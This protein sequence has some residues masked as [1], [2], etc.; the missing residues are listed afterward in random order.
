MINHYKNK[1]IAVAMSGGVDSSVSAALLKKQE[2]NVFGF[3]MVQFS[4]NIDKIDNI[5][6]EFINPNQ[7]INEMKSVIDAKKV[8]NYIGIPHF[9]IDLRKDFYQTVVQYFIEEYKNGKTPNPC[10][11]C[12]PTIKWGLF[13]DNIERILFNN[14]N[15]NDFLFATG[16]YAKIQQLENGLSAIFKAEDQKKDQTYMLWGL[17]QSQIT[18]TI[19]PL[20]GFR[21]DQSVA[22]EGISSVRSLA[23]E[24][25]LEIA[26]KKDSQDICFIKGKYSDF[27]AYFLDFVSGDIVYQ[28]IINGDLISKTIGKHK[29]LPLYTLG[30]RKGL[31]SWEKPLYVKSLNCKDNTV[32]VTDNNECLMTDTFFINNVNWHQSQMPDFDKDVCVQIRYNSSP[33]NI[34]NVEVLNNSLKITLDQPARSVTPGQSAVFYKKNMLLGGGIICL[35]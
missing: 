35:D 16:H 14:Y 26:E 12:N 3:T 2:A 33:K 27:L 23:S 1:N 29:G 19:F 32:I 22:G 13:I 9:A 24:I 8:C 4:D 11:L 20:S 25:G 30:Q 7:D 15:V 6:N 10:T 21:K 28:N 17:K 5:K 31:V 18:K 34:K